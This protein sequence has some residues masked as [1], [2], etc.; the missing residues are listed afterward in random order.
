[1][2]YLVFGAVSLAAVS[3]LAGLITFIKKGTA[4]IKEFDTESFRLLKEY[5]RISEIVGDLD[6]KVEARNVWAAKMEAHVGQVVLRNSQKE[7]GK[8]IKLSD[9]WKS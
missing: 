6:D 1:V 2:E 5:K 9:Y 8:V 7:K 3:A 4:K